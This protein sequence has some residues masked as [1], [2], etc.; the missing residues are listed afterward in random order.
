[1]ITVTA[2]ATNIELELKLIDDCT[3]ILIIKQKTGWTQRVTICSYCIR[4]T[5]IKLLGPF[6]F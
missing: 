5:V 3:R 6:S 1:M 2:S 4:I